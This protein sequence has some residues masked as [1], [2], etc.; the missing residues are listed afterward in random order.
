MT[1]PVFE[2]PRLTLRPITEHDAHGLHEAYGNADAM[3]YWDLPPSVDE[4]QTA[5]RIRV[6]A[7]ADARW[8][9]MWAIETRAGRFAGAINYHAHNEQHRR[10]SVGWIVVPSF[11][12]QG[13]MTEAAPPMIAHC[14]THL[15]AHRIEARI[16]PE[17]LSSRRLAAKLRFTEEGLLRDWL[18]VA[19]EFRSIVMHSLLRAEWESRPC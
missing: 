10:L 15:N 12:R 17:N 14:F 8:H 2:T 13:I 4:S 11:W 16:E 1:L 3:R 5:E 9:G 19:G 18:C 7:D 6:S